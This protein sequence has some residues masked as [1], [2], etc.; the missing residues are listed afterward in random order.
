MISA[1]CNVMGK[2]WKECG[3]SLLCAAVSIFADINLKAVTV[4]KLMKVF[5]S[6]N[7]VLMHRWESY[8]LVPSIKL[9]V[10]INLPQH[11][12]S[13][14][15][16]SRKRVET[17]SE[18]VYLIDAVSGLTSNHNDFCALLNLIALLLIF[19]ERFRVRSTLS[20]PSLYMFVPNQLLFG[21][22][23]SILMGLTIFQN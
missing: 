6:K 2:P 19:I 22:K 20:S 14:D 7:T 18:L 15:F 17:V 23:P 8:K 16:A 13:N 21:S 11:W 5:L 9:F 1:I 10:K 4:V 3:N 12:H